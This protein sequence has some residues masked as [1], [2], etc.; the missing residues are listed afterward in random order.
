MFLML[1]HPDPNRDKKLS[2][3]VMK[4]SNLSCCCSNHAFRCI[5]MRKREQE[6]N[7]RVNR[8]LQ[9]MK[10]PRTSLFHSFRAIFRATTTPLPPTRT[11]LLKLCRTETQCLT[12][13]K[14]LVPGLFSISGRVKANQLRKALI[15]LSHSPKR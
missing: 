1:D 11:T 9:A 5:T 12:K 4:V 2:E 6:I 8:L 13:T 10:E 3:H 15:S 14:P 7:L